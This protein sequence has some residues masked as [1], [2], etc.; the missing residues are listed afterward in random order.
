MNRME[1]IKAAFSVWGREHYRTTSLARLAGELGVTKAALY[2]HFTS[3]AALLEA[4][5]QYFCDSYGA[6][7]RPHAERALNARTMREGFSILIRS[8]ADFYAHNKYLFIFFVVQCH[9]DKKIQIY[10][11]KLRE[12][13]ISMT[14]LDALERQKGQP[15]YLDIVLGSAAFFTAFFY[16]KRQGLTADPPERTIKKFIDSLEEKIIHGL[17]FNKKTVEALNFDALEALLPRGFLER[18]KTEGLLKAVASVVAEEGPWN[19]SMEMIARRSGLS[20][21]GLY[22]HFKSKED[23][24]KTFFTLEFDRLTRYAVMSLERTGEPAERFYLA[25]AAI[26]DYLRWRP[27]ILVALNWIKELRIKPEQ[28]LPGGKALCSLFPGIIAAL[29]GRSRGF[30][31]EA[32]TYWILFLIIGVL[33]RVPEDSKEPNRAIRKLFKFLALGIEG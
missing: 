1:I 33:I 9:R 18:E 6:F 3:K 28:G 17:G 12:R 5:D 25:L 2:R 14:A 7:F 20:K 8:Q 24:L 13:G 26:A 4:M 27:E 10:A 23:M 29:P 30:A 22:S 16:K 21:S 31:D 11:E 15:R 19:V 32:M